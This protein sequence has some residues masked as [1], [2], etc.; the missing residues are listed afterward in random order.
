MS[1]TVKRPKKSELIS[2]DMRGQQSPLNFS[3]N[4]ENFSCISISLVLE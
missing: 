2:A 4:F 1:T 3:K